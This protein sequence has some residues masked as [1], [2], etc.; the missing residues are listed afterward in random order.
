LPDNFVADNDDY[1]TLDNNFLGIYYEKSKQPIDRHTINGQLK[2]L[3]DVASG[4]KFDRFLYNGGQSIETENFK[5]ALRFDFVND[6]YDKQSFKIFL[7]NSSYIIDVVGNRLVSTRTT[8]GDSVTT[9]IGYITTNPPGVVLNSF[10]G[11]NDIDWNR[12]IN[13]SITK[14]FISTRDVKYRYE[15]KML[16]NSRSGNDVGRE[17]I[18]IDSKSLIG[19]LFV[20]EYEK[21]DITKKQI[22]SFVV[23]TAADNNRQL[24]FKLGGE[25][26]FHVSENSGKYTIKIVDAL[27]TV[28]FKIDGDELW[29][30]ETK[31]DGTWVGEYDKESNRI[32]YERILSSK[33]NAA[34]TDFIDLRSYLVNF[35]IVEAGTKYR[36][37]I[38][39]TYKISNNNLIYQQD[40]DHKSGL[41]RLFNINTLR[42]R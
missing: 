11:G 36:I 39:P 12:L 15:L 40:F 18:T 7:A 6:I 25:I 42:N 24:N 3:K 37:N 35:G 38:K 20:D 41:F 29:A 26:R 31:I 33:N 34:L 23:E 22:G 13:Y 28:D 1:Y 27:A 19:R 14:S 17:F 30:S 16:S 8:G 10:G 21:L 5:D 2:S 4:I 9:D 32:S